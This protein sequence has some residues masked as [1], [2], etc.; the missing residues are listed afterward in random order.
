MSTYRVVYLQRGCN[1]DKIFDEVLK[2][3]LER[4]Q[5]HVIYRV[6]AEISIFS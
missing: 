5:F 4:A 2:L 3:L 1:V 6:S